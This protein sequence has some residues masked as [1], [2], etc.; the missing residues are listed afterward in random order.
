MNASLLAIFGYAVRI[1]SLGLLVRGSF[2][3]S[4]VHL[5]D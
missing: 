1:V 4:V 2:V 5:L 3:T